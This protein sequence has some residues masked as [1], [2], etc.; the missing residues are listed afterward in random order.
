MLS[1]LDEPRRAIDV[2]P[3]LFY[4]A[5]GSG[6]ELTLATGESLAHLNYL[7]GR[8][9]AV[10]TLGDDGLYWYRRSRPQ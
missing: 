2:F 7:I 1:D 9:E 3:S 10:R 5:I 8:G 4:R 6:R